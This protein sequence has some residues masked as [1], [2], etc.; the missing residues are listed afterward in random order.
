MSVVGNAPSMPG[1]ENSLPENT[2]ATDSTSLLNDALKIYLTLML[3]LS[4]VLFCSN[5]MVLIAK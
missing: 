4:F 2:S 3:A 5:V 1:S